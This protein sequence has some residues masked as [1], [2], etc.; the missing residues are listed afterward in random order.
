MTTT[1]LAVGTGLTDLLG[2]PFMR[3]ALLAGVPVAALAGV[4][5]YFM[6]LR[7]Q[8]FTADALSHVA[9]AGAL[10]A[11]AAG[12]DPRLGLFAATVVVALLLGLLGEGGRTDDVVIGTVFAWVLGLGVLALS[13]YTSQRSAGNGA[14]GVNVLFGSIFGLSASQARLSALLA[15]VILL[16]ALGIARPLLFASVDPALAAARGL[17]VRV[18]GV[19]FLVIAGATAAQTTQAVGALLLLGLLA[20]PAGA[21]R[22]LTDRPYRGMVLA[23]ALAVASMVTGLVASYLIPRV[24]PSFAILA[25]AT[26]LY[27]ASFAVRP[28]TQVP[29]GEHVH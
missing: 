13:I 24:P 4:V 22:R 29:V 27:A 1:T 28:A 8:V 17:P 3:H 23:A 12:V 9:F 15:V 19:G 6:V 18:L 20:A 5:G 7:S 2:H 16:L 11:L 14:A 26:A 10:G 21:A 25:V